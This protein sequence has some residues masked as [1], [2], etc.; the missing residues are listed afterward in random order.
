MKLSTLIGCSLCLA[1]GFL[2]LG[3]LPVNAQAPQTPQGGAGRGGKGGGGGGLRGPA[4][5]ELIYV[6]LPGSLERS[7]DHN[8]NGI[9]V[10]DAKNNYNFVKRIPVFDVRPARTPSRSPA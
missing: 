9:V 10:L 5:K 7:P 6:T 8:G 3:R 2:T 1:A 4:Q